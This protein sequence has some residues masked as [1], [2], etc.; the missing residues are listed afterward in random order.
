LTDF[1]LNVLDTLYSDPLVA[2]VALA[3]LNDGLL[4]LAWFDSLCVLEGSGGR[5]G[6]TC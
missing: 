1:V 6:A 5:E 4:V 3:F 2:F